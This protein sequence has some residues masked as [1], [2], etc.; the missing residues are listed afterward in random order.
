MINLLFLSNMYPE[1]TA[2][3]YKS[4]GFSAGGNNITYIQKSL[5]EGFDALDGVDC[6]VINKMLIRR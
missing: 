2:D 5:L 3:F 4:Q 6:T 1:E